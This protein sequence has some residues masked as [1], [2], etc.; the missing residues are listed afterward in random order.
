MSTTT[1][2]TPLADQA[3]RSINFFNGRLLTGGD[4]QRE[5]QA[6]QLAD[7]R[8]GAATGPG[9]AWGLEVSALAGSPAGRV[10]VEAG[11]G[12]NVSGAVL[13]L[14]T[15]TTLRL[16]APPAQA[17]ATVVSGFG[18]C[19]ALDSQTY[20]AGSGLFLLTLAPVTVAE[21]KAPVLAL[22]PVNTRCSTDVHVDA[23]QFRLLR[24]NETAAAPGGAAA[25]A[26]L[27]N[28]MAYTCFAPEALAAAHARPGTGS[29]AAL[30]P[31]LR[32]AGL[33]DCDLPLALVYLRGDT[34]E[35]IDRWAVRR[36][37]AAG[38]ASDAWA[39][40]LGERVT[41]LGEARMAQF[42]EHIVDTPA[43]LA[44]PAA[45]SLSWLPPAGFLPGSTAW[46]NF[47]GARAPA[48][49]TRVA[50][51]DV[52]AVLNAALRADAADLRLAAGGPAYRV[53]RI[54]GS[55]GPLLFVRDGR[56]LLHA[57][58]VWLDSARAGL[59]EIYDV[60][61]AIDSLQ[62]AIAL[63][64]AGT[65]LH[66]VLRP[67][68]DLHAVLRSLPAGKDVT[69]CFEP[70]LYTVS[71]PLLLQRLGSV[72]VHGAGARLVNEAGEC[73]LLI[74]S[75]TSARVQGLFVQGKRAG[76]GKQTLGVGLLGALTLLDTP[77]AGVH[78]VQAVCAGGTTLAAAA[79][80]LAVRKASLANL[81]AARWQVADCKLAVGQD[82]QGLLCVNASVLH[83]QRNHIAAADSKGRLQRGIVVGG[84]Q[85][86]SVHIEGNVV[87]DVVR[88]IAVGVSES[89]PQA[90]P[91]LR[92]DRVHV[93]RN[94]VQVHLLGVQK[95]GRFGIFIGNAGSVLATGNHVTARSA[96]AARL[97]LHGMR[98][99][100]FFGPQ[101]VV[102][103][104][105]FEETYKG[106]FFRPLERPSSF[107]WAFQ[108]NV[109]MRAASVVL[110]VPFD[111]RALVIDEHN[112]KVV[113]VPP[114][115]GPPTP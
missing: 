16:V 86:G 68:M 5:Q 64:Q 9:V 79:M 57:E 54:S 81:P 4:L 23:L 71:T 22:D 83:V 112:K 56:N 77:E 18:P 3:I 62:A 55:A 46:R 37:L 1:L 50:P 60:Q 38:G 45:D 98:L 65:C 107:V 26:R 75:C 39:A 103:D 82:Q 91:A 66:R 85:A 84:R 14:A 29:L 70:G 100:G 21:G 95:G 106:I 27:R 92:A 20:A 87:R 28:E 44:G 30:A 80:L 43:L 10:K 90:A 88:G 101:V 58:Q 49:E 74:D 59:P 19:K 115:P 32:V 48:R 102:R 8:V 73:A 63:L 96:D 41:A 42:Q 51:A 52:P 34:V 105:F 94:R 97:H 76:E 67:G 89:A 93:E 2:G 25:V 108:C 17:T 78:E 12:V 111:L 11:L 6:R 104:N 109:A 72:Q 110:D 31:A 47:L 69:L 33:T 53:Y 24:V 13:N 40:W 61:T 7:R 113:G 99:T 35:F 15:S 36:R 114:L